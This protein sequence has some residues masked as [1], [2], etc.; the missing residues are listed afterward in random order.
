MVNLFHV[1]MFSD[2]FGK[3]VILFFLEFMVIRNSVI[4]IQFFSVR[5]QKEICERR[6][7]KYSVYVS[8]HALVVAEIPVLTAVCL[9]T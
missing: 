1:N 7:I 4:F 9:H 2:M 8:S 5:L 6:I 3:F